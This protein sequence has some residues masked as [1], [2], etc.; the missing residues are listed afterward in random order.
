MDP[1]STDTTSTG[2]Y[3][4]VAVVLSFLIAACGSAP[5]DG[6]A[7]SVH[8]TSGETSSSASYVLEGNVFDAVGVT[9]ASYTLGTADPA[10]VAVSGET[11]R[12]NLTLAPGPNDIM[13]QASDA[14]GNTGS[15]SI[16]VDYQA[17]PADAAANTDIAAR[18]DTVVIT[19]SNFG[20]DGEV[21]IGGV[22]APASVW[23]D[24]EVTFDV[25]M[26]APSGPQELVIHG[27]YG[28]TSLQLFVGVDFP[29]GELEDLVAM[30]LPRGTA[31]RL[32][33]G[34]YV[35]AGA[36]LDPIRFD[37]LSLYGQGA[38]E[39]LLDFTGTAGLELWADLGYDIVVGELR[40]LSNTVLFGPGLAG[41][42]ESAAA[43]PAADLAAAAAQPASLEEAQES[44]LA[45]AAGHAEA[46]AE[47]Q[48]QAATQGSVTFSNGRFED[49][50]GGMLRSAS[51]HAGVQ[52]YLGSVHFSAFE[53]DAPL[54]LVHLRAP[55]GVVLIDSDIVSA[56]FDLSSFA[57]PLVI[58]DTSLHA[59]AF[60]TILGVSGL[61]ISGGDFSGGAGAY[62][63]LAGGGSL[64]L[65]LGGAS[66]I[67]GSDIDVT[68]IA[69]GAFSSPVTVSGN[70]IA[71]T[72]GISITADDS[73]VLLS[74]NDLSIGDSAGP[75]ADLRLTGEGDVSSH[76]E[77]RDND[78]RFLVDGGVAY[79][80]NAHFVMS[81]NTVTGNAGNGTAL[82]L[83]QG[84]MH[85]PLRVS[86]TDNTFVDFE[87]AL[88]LEADLGATEPF[89]AAINDNVFDF[90][91]DATPKAA[92][93]FAINGSVAQLDATNNVW[94]GN[95]DATA[96]EG[97]ILY[98]GGSTATLVVDPISEP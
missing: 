43:S 83:E 56:S 14:A 41:P 59:A 42:I 2:L 51:M 1:R 23:S 70:T 37:N 94:G 21:E 50:T 40:I 6:T 38:D 62:S 44:A 93:V 13:V 18:G 3:L 34:T 98:D 31:V 9:Q 53:V 20:S 80:G 73:S 89:E 92:T 74:N 63:L 69:I 11:F 67:S 5:R 39:T 17:A 22:A 58:H 91:I 10:P 48:Q 4:A 95:T 79:S 75:N 86:V 16:T 55:A 72:D 12:A 47:L 28:S 64:G 81:G 87:A 49:I 88:Y 84:N 52:G 97:Y 77:L 35:P 85:Q 29:P 7:P 15:A 30:E 82:S 76:I 25:P 26:N 66:S 96:V 61:D 68:A 45:W 36:T 8:I 19:G 71:A 65:E 78:V 60:G 57:T 27:P 90:T 46:A 33:A 54:S 32:G 24:T